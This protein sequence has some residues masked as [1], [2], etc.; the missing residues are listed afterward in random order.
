MDGT[1]GLNR[2]NMRNGKSKKGITNMDVITEKTLAEYAKKSSIV[3]VVDDQ[4]RSF[5]G[6]I[7]LLNSN[8][9]GST[10]IF[11]EICERQDDGT[12]LL[13]EE[14]YI[15]DI[16]KIKSLTVLYEL[17]TSFYDVIKEYILS[18][19]K[20]NIATSI[21]TLEDVQIIRYHPEGIITVSKDNEIVHVNLS[22]IIYILPAD[23]KS[24]DID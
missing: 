12:Y 1:S 7:T 4:H 10:A 24:S 22:S 9:C 5:V 16:H 14:S 21:N 13:K 3:K 20:V 19:V 2:L 11:I 15:L 8:K 23:K 18:N 6:T 17:E